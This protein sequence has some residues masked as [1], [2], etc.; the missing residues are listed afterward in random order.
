M[1][2]A[3][4]FLTLCCFALY[5]N[6]P[7]AQAGLLHGAARL[8]C[9][10]TAEA[11]VRRAIAQATPALAQAD[12]VSPALLSEPRNSGFRVVS[13]WSDKLR[14]QTWATVESC[15]QAGLPRRTLPVPFNLPTRPLLAPP[16]IRRGD[17][18]LVSTG[19]SGPSTA[20]RVKLQG[21][22]ETSAAAGE[23]LRV[24]LPSLFESPAPSLLCRATAAGLAEVAE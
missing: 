12:T 4:P 3:V 22:A 16:V 9:A 7:Q 6:Q 21:I 24:R 19:G 8:A 10:P 15:V 17:T 1:H 11:A 5:G 2:K 18:V 20:T 13:L 23:S 14:A